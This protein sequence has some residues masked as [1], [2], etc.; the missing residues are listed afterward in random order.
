V[1]ALNFFQYPI[2]HSITQL[3]QVLVKKMSAVFEYYHLGLRNLVRQEAQAFDRRK[4]VLIAMD[5][6]YRLFHLDQKIVIAVFLDR[7]SD[8]DQP[9]HRGVGHSNFH[10]NTRTK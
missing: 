2:S 10:S 7:R 3:P 6:K 1:F 8:A 4:F 5:K 9:N